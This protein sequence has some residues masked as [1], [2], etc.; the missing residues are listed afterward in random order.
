VVAPAAA[1]AARHGVSRA[2]EGTVSANLID[3]NLGLD[4]VR[5][6]EA[7]ALAAA[8]FM[9]RGMKNE[10]D[11]ASVNAMR[12]ALSSIDMDGVVVIGEGEKDEAPMLYIG[13]QIGNGRPPRVDIAVDP[14]DGTRLLAQ[15]MPNSVSVVA[16]AERGTMFNPPG[17][18]YMDKLAVGPLARGKVDIQAPVEENLEA[19]RQAK[20]S[21]MAE[22][23]ICILDRPRHEEL[24]RRVR[25]AGARIKLITDGDVAGS[26]Q[27]ATPTVG[28][29]ALM[30]VGGAPEAVISA[31][32]MK[33]LGGEIQ[34]LLWPRND[35]ERRHA[36]EQ[37]LPLGEV[38][39][40]DRLCAGENI[41]VSV[42]GITDGELVRGVRYHGAGASTHTLA[43]R[44]RSGTIRY[45]EAHHRWDKL[46]QVANLPYH[47]Q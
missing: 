19:I 2:E 24:I 35:Q 10:A 36:E 44:S 46:M 37:G 6:T 4:L 27:A 30:G 8:R 38:L 1:S 20:G 22:V 28:V 29:D 5:V 26:I 41:F 13:E 18:V 7:S 17:I 34:C 45:I 14:I 21:T 15:G 43:M 31:A 11:G 42:T 25:A 12:F 16:L 33:C 32:A 40:T 39:G 9:G 3:R 47:G 23:T